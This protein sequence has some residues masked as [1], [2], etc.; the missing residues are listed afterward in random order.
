MA[1]DG[2]DTRTINLKGR[3]VV[4]GIVDNHNHIV[5]M[6]NRPGYHTPLENAYS[7]EDVQETYAERAEDIP[8]GAWI[9]TIGGFHRNHLVP[10]SEAP[11][12]P[13][14]AELDEA[15]PDNPVYISEAFAGPSATNTLGK[16][17]FESRGIPVGADGSI[18]AGFG[19]SPTG[20]ATFALRQTLLSFDER[21]RGTIDAIAYG[22]SLGVTTHIDEGAFQT[23][24]DATD[25]PRTRTTTRCTSRSSPST[26]TATSTPACGSTSSTWRPTR[27]RPGSSN[28]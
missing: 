17:F 26:T 28:G 20:Q 5:L 6:G 3:T 1:N 13:T 24:G 10:P 12:L 9:T 4:P 27:P 23:A 7:I 11:R 14:L 25:G 22:L 16:A 18:A 8:D 21:K 15:V 19:A 2:G